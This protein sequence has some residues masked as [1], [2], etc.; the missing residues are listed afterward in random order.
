[1][2]TATTRPT[3]LS[4]KATHDL[5]TE[6]AIFLYVVGAN[7]VLVLDLLLVSMC[8]SDGCGEYYDGRTNVQTHYSCEYVSLYGLGLGMYGK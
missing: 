7:P 2:T 4:G 5:W 3:G 1:M 6:V 8:C